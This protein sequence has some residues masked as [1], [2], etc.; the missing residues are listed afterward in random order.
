M[1]G[2]AFNQESRC[3]HFKHR[4]PVTDLCHIRMCEGVVTDLVPLAIHA[5]Y[6][7]NIILSIQSYKEERCRHM[8]L[9][10]Y[11]ENLW[12]KCWIGTIIKSEHQ[13]FLI[14]CRIT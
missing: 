4:P 9:S 7:W 1:S 11:I 14:P 8:F 5:L 3:F 6:E 12:S 2:D 13:F 10:K